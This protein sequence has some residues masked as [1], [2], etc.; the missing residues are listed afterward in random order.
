MTMLTAN[1]TPTAPDTTATLADPRPSW[2]ARATA[3]ATRI[4]PDAPAFDR[5]GTFVQPS[6]DLLRAE[7]FLAAPVP[8]ELGG[9]GATYPETAAILTELAKGCPATA[10]TLS[11]HYHLVCTQLWRHRR[12][13][14]GEALLRKVAADNVLLVS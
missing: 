10:V 4:A 1:H 11:M 3:A 14:P 9:G 7:G 2:A 13:L 12:G 6:F 8:T 5:A